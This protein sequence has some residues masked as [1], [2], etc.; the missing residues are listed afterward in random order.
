MI[1]YPRIPTNTYVYALF[2][3]TSNIKLIAPELPGNLTE[4]DGTMQVSS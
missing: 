1:L 4:I 2:Q 3:A